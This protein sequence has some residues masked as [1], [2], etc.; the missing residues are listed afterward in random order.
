MPNRRLIIPVCAG[1]LLAACSSEAAKQAA[2]ITDACVEL[3]D[4]KALCSCLADSMVASLDQETLA[5]FTSFMTSL[6][7]ADDDEARNVIAMSAFQN[8]ALAVG[9]DEGGRV[10]RSCER[11]VAS[12]TGDDDASA[13]DGGDLAGSWVPQLGDVPVS[14]RRL[15][16]AAADRRWEFSADGKVTTYSQGGPRNWTYQ[17]R[18][19]DIL[20][21]MAGRT[22]SL[23]PGPAP[24]HRFPP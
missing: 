18:G 24:P 16:A 2:I 11:V 21:R 4:D 15:A 12:Q 20:F 23:P 17:V 19:K 1:V 22:P 13:A 9:I 14:E 10:G 5:T 3:G 8:P 6:V 7:A